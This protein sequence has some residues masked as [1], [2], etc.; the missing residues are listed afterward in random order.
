MMEHLDWSAAI[1]AAIIALSAWY[2]RRGSKRDSKTLKVTSDA[3]LGAT[4]QI[5]DRLSDIEVD[6]ALV[7]RTLF[8]E[9]IVAKEPETPKGPERG[10]SI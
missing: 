7:K 8:R 1:Q 5:L 3:Q 2:V 9:S 10:K 6:L 4:Q